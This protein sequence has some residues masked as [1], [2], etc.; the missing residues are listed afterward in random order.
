[1]GKVTY[2]RHSAAEEIL[3][4]GG[5]P[6][7]WRLNAGAPPF[8]PGLGRKLVRRLDELVKYFERAPVFE[9]EESRAFLLDELR[10]AR[11]RWAKGEWTPQPS[12]TEAATPK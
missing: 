7:A 5:V 6:A 10:A 9:D 12:G 11:V 2:E 8:A 4:T 1:V 3:A